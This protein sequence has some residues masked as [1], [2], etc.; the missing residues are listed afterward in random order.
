MPPDGERTLLVPGTQATTLRDHLGNVV[1]NAVRVQLVI[2]RADLGDRD[3]EEVGMLLGMEHTPG[4]LKP[5]RTSLEDGTHVVRGDVL[6]TPYDGLPVTDWFRYDWRADLR[7]NAYKL[8]Q[9]LESETVDGKRWNVIGHSQGALIIVLASKLAVSPRWFAER[10]GRVVLVGGPIAGTVRALE[11][12]LFGRADLGEENLPGIL[13]AA[14]TWPAL[15]QMLPAWPAAVDGDDGPLPPEEQFTVPG[16]WPGLVDVPGG[17]SSDLLQRARETQALLT[18]P[19]SHLAPGVDTLVIMGK[20]QMT[21]ISVPRKDGAFVQKYRNQKGDS[22]VP[23]KI[24]QT[25]I[26]PPVYDR[27]KIFT[28]KVQ[29]HAMLCVDPDVQRLVGTF[30]RQP[31]PPLPTG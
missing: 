26:G 25:L 29:A 14:R 2:G 6:R 10:V 24:T 17:V 21:P 31:L 22:L 3:P 7:Y 1:Y 30:F 11:A 5:E 20:R 4:K 19:F 18:G 23:E 12:I 28:G 15:Y 16:G 8:L 9:L 27:R 13:A